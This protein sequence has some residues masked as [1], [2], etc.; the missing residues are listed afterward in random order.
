[1]RKIIEEITMNNTKQILDSKEIELS[2]GLKLITV[3]KS[4]RIASV[5]MGFKI[6]AMD[7]KKNERGICHFIEHMLFKGTLNRNNYD[8]N[9]ALEERGG[10]Y[11]AYTDYSSTVYSITALAEE[12]EAS[13]DILSDIAMNSIFPEQE[14]IKE[15]KV[16]LAEISANMDDVEEY[17][18][19]KTNEAAYEKGPLKFEIIGSEK[20]INLFTKTQLEFFYDKNYVPNNCIISIVSPYDHKLMEAMISKYYA[21]WEKGQKHHRKVKKEKN[22]SIEKQSFKKN[23]EQNTIIFLYNFFNLSRKEEIALE[24]L[25]HK[26]G[27][28]SNSILFRRLREEK[29]V[30]YDVYSEIDTNDWLKTLYIYTAV[31]PGD[32]LEAKNIIVD[33]ITDIIEKK[34]V[35]TTKD[36]ELMKKVIRTGV[37]SMLEDSGGLCSYILHQKLQDLKIDG[38]IEDMLMLESISQ[39]DIYKV[40]VKIFDDPTIHI[41]VDKN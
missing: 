41:L 18:F 36:I 25:N 19:R 30:S 16:I 2:N 17:S 22:R 15:K 40:G 8:I 11:N 13:V 3:K 37:A 10:Y 5:H 24:I 1:M 29:G 12:L 21:L 38:F 32:T 23:I 33:C 35:I 34:T 28:S 39:E 9:Q 26:L 27:V 6:G 20:S 4:T 7:E 31:S 14:I